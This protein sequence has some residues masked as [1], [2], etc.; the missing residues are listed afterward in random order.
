MVKEYILKLIELNPNILYY[1]LTMTFGL[2]LKELFKLL[3]IKNYI[4]EDSYLN[5]YDNNDNKVY[6]EHSNGYWQKWEC[7]SN[8]N[9]IYSINST[10]Y[11]Y[12]SKYDKY[13]NET[14]FE[15]SKGMKHKF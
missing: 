6:E 15:D 11:W 9:V 10:G 1:E 3:D 14:Y 13:G 7:D 5:I 8:G 2:P 12:K 4:I